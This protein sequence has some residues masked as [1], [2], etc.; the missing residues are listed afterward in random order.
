MGRFD[1]LMLKGDIVQG[2]L[3]L[4]VRLFIISFIL[5]IAFSVILK[6]MNAKCRIPGM[7]FLSLPKLFISVF[8]ILLVFCFDYKEEHLRMFQVYDMTAATFFVGILAIMECI[9][10]LIS[11]IKEFIECNKIKFD[12]W[13]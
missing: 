4:C 5:M 2:M 3:S 7:W 8:A 13:K 12:F 1:D 9:Y 10:T 6:R 11:M